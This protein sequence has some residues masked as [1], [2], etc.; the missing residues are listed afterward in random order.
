MTKGDTQTSSLRGDDCVIG[1]GIYLYAP[2]REIA[3]LPV[4]GQAHASWIE[5]P[6]VAQ[7]PHLLGVRMPTGE[8]RCIVATQ[9]LPYNVIWR[10]G[11]NDLVEGTRRSMKT[12]QGLLRLQRDLDSGAKLLDKGDVAF[13]ELRERPSSDFS[14]LLAGFFTRGRLLARDQPGIGV[15]HH[16]RAI[17]LAQPRNCLCWLRSPLKRITQTHHLLNALSPDILK[18]LVKSETFTVNIGN[19]RK[20]HRSI[21]F[22]I[23]FC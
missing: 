8:Q 11:E 17:Q 6:G 10:I 13:R 16:N 5:I 19:N 3:I 7:A 22:L 15:A 12:E 4:I 14:L 18:Y 23:F 1:P 20:T 9:E 21:P 2:L